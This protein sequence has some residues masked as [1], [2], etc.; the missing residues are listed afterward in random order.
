VEFL[1]ALLGA[2]LEPRDLSALNV[3]ARAVFMFFSA[4]IMIRLGDKRFLS[5]KTPYDAVVG[6]IL[7]SMLA[8]DVNGSAAIIPT[9]AGGFSIVLLHRFLAMLSSRFHGIGVLVKGRSNL[10]IQDGNLR[11]KTLKSNSLSLGDVEE[12]LRLNGRVSDISD[13]QTAYL[14]RNGQISVIP[15]K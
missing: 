11:Y 5:R 13:V 9:L 2:G 10:I 4:L 7:A 6:F 8:R 1:K 3:V 14:E 12:D 15:K